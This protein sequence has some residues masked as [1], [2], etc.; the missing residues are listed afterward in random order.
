MTKGSQF[1]GQSVKPGSVEELLQRELKALERAFNTGNEGALYEAICLCKSDKAFEDIASTEF[2][3][4]PG[5]IMPRWM[6]EA[7]ADRQA[8]YLLDV[9]STGTGRNAKWRSRFRQDMIDYD[10]HGA[11]LELREHPD[12]KF[13]WEEIYERIS[14]LLTGTPAGGAPETIKGSYHRVRRRMEKNPMRYKVF[15]FLRI[16]G[17]V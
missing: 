7:I 4:G 16:K 5:V 15:R 2:L 9:A 17:L 12:L 10:R 3:D 14:D 11:V 13:T 1:V 6:V 8:R